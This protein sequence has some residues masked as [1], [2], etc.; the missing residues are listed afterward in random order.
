M[1]WEWYIEENRKVWSVV[2]TDGQTTN[3]VA[4]VYNL[5]DANAIVQDYRAA[6]MLKRLEKAI[7]KAFHQISIAMGAQKAERREG[8]K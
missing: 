5:C 6:P 8:Q 1:T 7:N 3:V 2:A 4:E